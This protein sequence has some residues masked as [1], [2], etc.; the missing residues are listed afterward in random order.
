MWMLSSS[1]EFCCV[2]QLTIHL[3]WSDVDVISPFSSFCFLFFSCLSHGMYPTGCAFFLSGDMNV[4]IFIRILAC[5]PIDYLPCLKWCECHFFSSVFLF[6]FSLTLESWCVCHWIPPLHICSA[7]TWTLFFHIVFAR[8]CQLASVGCTWRQ[9]RCTPFS[10]NLIFYTWFS[11]FCLFHRFSPL[12]PLHHTSPT[13][14]PLVYQDRFKSLHPCYLWDGVNIAIS[15]WFCLFC[16]WWH[17]CHQ[18]PLPPS[19]KMWTS[20]TLFFYSVPLAILLVAWMSSIW[21]CGWTL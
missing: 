3:V 8:V 1:V 2:H 12:S 4:I 9:S 15:Y 11:P 14:G 16:F 17:V 6:S 7:V 21:L 5:T 19:A 20:S 13:F 10:L 18:M